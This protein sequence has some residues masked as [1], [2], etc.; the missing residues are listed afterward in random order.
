M[1]PLAVSLYSFR[2]G[3]FSRAAMTGLSHQ[4]FKVSLVFEP[5]ESAIQ[6]PMTG[7]ETGVVL[8]LNLLGDP[9]AVKLSVATTGAELQGGSE[10][11]VLYG[12]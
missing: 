7:K 5:A 12:D 6:S 2:S 8:P 9:E 3:R 11:R 1:I 4:A 10:N